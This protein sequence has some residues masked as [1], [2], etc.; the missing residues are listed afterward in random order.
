[1]KNISVPLMVFSG[2]VMGMK[3]IRGFKKQFQKIYR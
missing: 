1:M 2:G 3:K